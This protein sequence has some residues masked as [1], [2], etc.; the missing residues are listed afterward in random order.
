[1][2]KLFSFSPPP[3]PGLSPNSNQVFSFSPPADSL[4]EFYRAPRATSEES[5]G[6]MEQDQEAAMD[7]DGISCEMET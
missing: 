2:L 6:A 5:S 3:P 1:M 4:G 7:E